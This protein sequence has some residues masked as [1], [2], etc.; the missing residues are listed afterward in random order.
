MFDF[1]FKLW[2]HNLFR[3]WDEKWYTII[4]FLLHLTDK[5]NSNKPEHYIT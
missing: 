2:R 4:L 5:Q 1:D 3:I